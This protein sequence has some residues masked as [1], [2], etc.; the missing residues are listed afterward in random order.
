MTRHVY[1]TDEVCHLWAHGA[2]RDLRNSG[3]RVFTIHGPVSDT[4]YSYGMHFPMADRIILKDQT[5]VFLVNPDS[6]SVTTSGHQGAVRSAIQGIG[7]QFPLPV[8]FWKQVKVGGGGV[9]IRKYFQSLIDSAMADANNNRM[10]WWRRNQACVS[11]TNYTSLYRA[12]HMIFK[13]RER[14]GVTLP[15]LPNL[16]ESRIKYDAREKLREEQREEDRKRWDAEHK[17]RVEEQERKDKELRANLPE[18]I[19]KWRR[20]EEV[21]DRFFPVMMRIKNC[22]IETTM[23][24]RVEVDDVICFIEEDLQRVIATGGR[25]MDAS[26]GPYHGVTSTLDYLSIGCHSFKWEEVNRMVRTLRRLRNG[27]TQEKD[28]SQQTEYGV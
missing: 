5:V 20:G 1:P 2:E 15:S 8:H 21:D 13:F 12:L 27:E 14:K 3:Y 25:V 9:E 10:G 6:Y 17:L 22:K 26:V 7:H 23:G 18:R 4:I 19:T 11:V 24:A 16:T 28:Q